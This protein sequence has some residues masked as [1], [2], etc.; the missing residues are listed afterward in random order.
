MTAWRGAARRG[1]ARRG[2]AFP[3]ER[4]LKQIVNVSFVKLIPFKW[5]VECP[6]I[7]LTHIP[8]AV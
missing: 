4:G 3:V 1:A 8:V 7:F 6:L 5:N 2:V